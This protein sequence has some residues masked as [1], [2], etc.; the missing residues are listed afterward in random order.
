M[1]PRFLILFEGGM[2]VVE[3]ED[4]KNE[5]DRLK[6]F[7]LD[8]DSIFIGPGLNGKMSELNAVIGLCQLKYIDSLIA[9]RKIIDNK[10][11]ERLSNTDGVTLYQY[12]DNLEPNYSY[13]PILINNEYPISRDSLVEKL[14]NEGV[15]ARKY[16]LPHTFRFCG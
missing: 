15:L 12:S 9:Q 14:K 3:S 10:Y 13:F 11:R 5:V 2:V 8:P 6:N 16:F 4:K 1:R 7:G